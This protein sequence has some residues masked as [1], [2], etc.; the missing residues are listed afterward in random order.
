MWKYNGLM[1]PDHALLEELSDDE[2]WS[3]LG[4]VL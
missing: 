1:D 2:V 4:W 3:H